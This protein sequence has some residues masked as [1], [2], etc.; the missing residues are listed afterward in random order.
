MKCKVTVNN[1]RK[2]SEE[3][4][5]WKAQSMS[6]ANPALG[7]TANVELVPKFHVALHAS[8]A[9]LPMISWSM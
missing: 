1:L 3:I 2:V 8:N 5:G 6:T 9:A 4:I 7:L